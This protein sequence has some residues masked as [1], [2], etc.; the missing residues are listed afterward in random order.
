MVPPLW[1]I[2][3]LTSA[4]LAGIVATRTEQPGSVRSSMLGRIAASRSAAA[5]QATTT[6]TA[7]CGRTELPDDVMSFYPACQPR[8]T[9]TLIT[10]VDAILVRSNLGGVGGRCNANQRERPLNGSSPGGHWCSEGETTNSTP[11]ELY[12]AR[13][14]F[15]P[16]QEQIDLRITN[17]SE[18][19]AWNANVNGG[20]CARRGR[21]DAIARRS[22]RSPT[23]LPCG[24]S[25]YIARTCHV[26]PASLAAPPLQS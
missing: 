4:D 25:A 8:D 17:V 15:T 9:F 5:A 11:H 23:R 3:A 10:L 19:R 7:A 21:A 24:K 13:V 22:L 1:L 2:V 20:A 6:T 26:I 16:T 12:L 18:Y 14:G